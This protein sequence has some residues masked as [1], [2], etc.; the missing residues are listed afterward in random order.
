MNQQ[1]TNAR[2]LVNG[3]PPAVVLGEL[4]T[5]VAKWFCFKSWSVQEAQEA[6]VDG[7]DCAW[8]M[9]LIYCWAEGSCYYGV[10]DWHDCV[11]FLWLFLIF[12]NKTNIFV[13]GFMPVYQNNLGHAQKCIDR[14][15]LEG[16]W[17]WVVRKNRNQNKDCKGP[18]K[19][20]IEIGRLRSGSTTI[21][22]CQSGNH[23]KCRSIR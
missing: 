23:P 21:I 20:G 22:L 11:M 13:G 5:D 9:G 16:V 14:G 4:M 17:P 3:W 6:G 7:G 10:F 19:N 18:S 8:D 2:I 12:Q 1:T 15:Y